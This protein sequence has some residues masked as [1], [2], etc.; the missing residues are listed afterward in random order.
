[1]RPVAREEALALLQVGPAA[2]E[3]GFAAIG[4]QL[5]K[6]RFLLSLGPEGYSY[7]IMTIDRDAPIQKIG[8]TV[9]RTKRERTKRRTEAQAGGWPCPDSTPADRRGQIQLYDGQDGGGRE[10][11]I[12]P[13]DRGHRNIVFAPSHILKRG[14]IDE[15][16]KVVFSIMRR[17]EEYAVTVTKDG[18]EIRGK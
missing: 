11:D 7:L 3:V 12:F 1:M 6:T 10:G 15:R 4:Y 13:I 2:R 5:A 9:Y 8:R 16:Y 14:V 18:Y 17:N